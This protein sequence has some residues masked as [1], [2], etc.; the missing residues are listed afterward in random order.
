MI[1]MKHR[2]SIAL[3]L[4]TGLSHTVRYLCISR[5]VVLPA[6][7]GNAISH[8]YSCEVVVTRVDNTEPQLSQDIN[9]LAGVLHLQTPPFSL[10]LR[11]SSII[12]S[13]LVS[14]FFSTIAFAALP[15]LVG[16]V[17]VQS[18]SRDVIS[19]PISKRSKVHKA[20]TA[21]SLEA[22]IRQTTSFVL[23]VIFRRRLDL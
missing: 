10:T 15:F 9:G 2:L 4:T 11:S 6:C 23:P 13:P 18:S 8:I 19:I 17:S 16:A 3:A 12:S 1:T 20:V 7:L 14:Y 21:E 5:K 22:N